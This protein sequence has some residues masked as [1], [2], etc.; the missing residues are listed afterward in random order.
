MVFLIDTYFSPP[1]F[2]H[3][4]LVL[5]K[6]CKHGMIC[7]AYFSAKVLENRKIQRGNLD[8]VLETYNIACNFI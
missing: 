5:E 8:A 3:R 2:Y 7:I 1:V 6:N 4:K